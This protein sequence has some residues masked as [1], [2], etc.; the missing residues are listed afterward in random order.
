MNESVKEP[1]PSEEQSSN[2][3]KAFSSI[4][5][6]PF[7]LVVCLLCGILAVSG[8]LSYII[9]QGTF[10]RDE[11]DMIIPELF[12]VGEVKGI[13]IWRV[14]TAPFRVFASEDA[15]TIIM[16]SVFLL[17]M[18]GV[19][20]LLDKTGG[21]RVVIGKTMQKFANSKRI[22]VC[23]TALIFMA[24]GSFFGLF[25]ELVTLL[26]IVVLFMLSLGFDTL[27][28]LGVCMMSACFGFAA[29]ITN[30]FS[31]GLIPDQAAAL[32]IPFNVSDGVWLRIVLLVLSQE[33]SKQN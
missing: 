19:F 31:V 24:F 16:I 5:I 3:D 13:A 27:T 29:A 26:P 33:I 1:L 2:N 25:E 23:V 6:K 10:A 9:P 8:I 22:V 32:N 30:P 7:I 4:G 21:I 17:I 20:N 28:G 11:N 15:L 18:S 14:L 12:Q